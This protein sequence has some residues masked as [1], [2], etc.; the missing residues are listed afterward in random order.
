VR[1]TRIPVWG[2]IERRRNGQA[3][4]DILR[5]LPELTRADLA[6][7]WEYAAGHPDEIERSLWENEA[8]MVQHDGRNVPSALV[9]RGRQLGLSD[10]DLRNAF[11][12]PLSQDE[13]NAALAQPPEA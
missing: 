1:D 8:C 13:L 5:S 11:E 12:P 2:L 6:A 10:D 7:A 4:A 9:Q 3:D